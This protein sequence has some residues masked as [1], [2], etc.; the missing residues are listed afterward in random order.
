MSDALGE[1]AVARTHTFEPLPLVRPVNASS[2]A[3]LL[4]MM[5]YSTDV[6]LAS[7]RTTTPYCWLVSVLFVAGKAMTPSGGAAS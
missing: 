2:F 7:A 4:S 6:T 3:A 5:L 1:T